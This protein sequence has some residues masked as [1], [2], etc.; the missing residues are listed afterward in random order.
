M[1]QKPE[2]GFLP[3]IFFSGGCNGKAENP[4]RIHTIDCLSIICAGFRK[5][6][7]ENAQSASLIFGKTQK[8][9]FT[10]ERFFNTWYNMIVIFRLR[11]AAV[12]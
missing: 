6:S 3:L 12:S 7:C 11:Q 4:E 1:G 2:N 9:I 10:L 8:I 5:K